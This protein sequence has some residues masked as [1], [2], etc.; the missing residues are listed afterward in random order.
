M[1][2]FVLAWIVAG[3]AMAG[4]S[5]YIE[6]RSVTGITFVREDIVWLFVAIVLCVTCWPLMVGAVAGRMYRDWLEGRPWR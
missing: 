1:T 5:T 6:S 2:I 4:Y 3:L